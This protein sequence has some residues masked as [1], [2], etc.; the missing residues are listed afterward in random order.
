VP[1]IFDFVPT[2]IFKKPYKATVGFFKIIFLSEFVALFL[3]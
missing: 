2:T 1:V 3:K